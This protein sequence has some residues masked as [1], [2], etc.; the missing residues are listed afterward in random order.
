MTE[1]YQCPYDSATGCNMEIG[2]NGCQEWAKAI[3]ENQLKI[4][5]IHKENKSDD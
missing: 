4:I 2:C 3:N 1:L 5:K